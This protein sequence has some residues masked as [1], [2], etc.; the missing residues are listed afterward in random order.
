MELA[1]S[2][3][4]SSAV[5]LGF[6]ALLFAPLEALLP[7]RVMRERAPLSDWLMFV[8][9]PALAAWFAL[10]VLTVLAAS[11][12]ETLPADVRAFTSGAPIAV[13]LA[14]V[15]LLAQLW[16]Y[17]VHRLSHRFNLLWRFHRLHHTIEQ[18]RWI[19]AHRQ[20]PVD[21]LLMIAG[22]NLPA[23]VLGV[24]LRPLA[25]FIVIE[26]LYTVLLH[27]NLDFSFGWFDRIIAS[28]RFHH[29]HHDAGGT[30]QH[31]NFAGMFSLMDWVFGTWYPPTEPPAAFGPGDDV[32]A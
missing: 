21:V 4:V 22:A 23:F 11:I 26:R 13:Q 15:V 25:G 18:M 31:H 12:R 14:L 10:A 29:W 19:S 6:S 8:L 30:G 17:W 20:H 24:D 5:F 28:P 3:L 9:N 1:G 32:A 27:T 2:I 16:T 7:A